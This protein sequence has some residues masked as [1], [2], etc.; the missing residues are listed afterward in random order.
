MK[1][2][3]PA[4]DHDLKNQILLKYHEKDHIASENLH[5]R[6]REAFVGISRENC[7]NFIESCSQCQ[8]SRRP[9]VNNMSITPI[10]STS[11]R[12]RLIIDAVDFRRYHLQN[13]GYKYIFT[14]IDSFTKF[15]WAFPT[16]DKSSLTFSNILKTFLMREGPWYI[17]H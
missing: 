5:L 14:F 17:I 16:K 9:V 8:R 10:I 4:Y 2:V 1:Q 15:A 6:I 11:P 7:K 13:S 12:E 3:I